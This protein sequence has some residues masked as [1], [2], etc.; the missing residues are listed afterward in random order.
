MDAGELSISAEISEPP[1]TERSACQS[2]TQPPPP[3]PGR[4]SQRCCVRGRQHLQNADAAGSCAGRQRTRK[5]HKGTKRSCIFAVRIG[6]H[7]KAYRGKPLEARRADRTYPYPKRGRSNFKESIRPRTGVSTL[8][9]RSGR[10]TKQANRQ[11]VSGLQKISTMQ[12]HSFAGLINSLT[13][14]PLRSQ[15]P[16]LNAV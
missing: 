4:C 9:G 10:E 8:R 14:Q 12:G 2:S 16:L 7:H 11:S 6:P 13:H 3:S 1:P 15:P 5:L